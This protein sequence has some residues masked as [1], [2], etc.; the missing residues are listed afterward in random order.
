MLLLFCFMALALALYHTAPS[1]RK[2]AAHAGLICAAA[3]GMVLFADY[4][5]Q[6]SVVQPSLLAGE[7]D[8]IALLTQYNPH[9]LFVVFEEIGYLLMSLSFLCFSFLFP[10]KNRLEAGLRHTLRAA[11]WLSVLSFAGICIALG[12]HREYLFEVAVIS[13]DFLALIVFGFLA[14]RRFRRTTPAT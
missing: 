13:I 4:F 8:G 7:T 11:F 3:S 5:V 10:A 1:G 12:L 9:G 2:P 14:A 6:V